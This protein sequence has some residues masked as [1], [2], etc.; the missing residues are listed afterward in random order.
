VD[1]SAGFLHSLELLE[2]LGTSATLVAHGTDVA[3]P[4]I[5]VPDLQSS[6]ADRRL[7]DLPSVWHAIRHVRDRRRLPEMPGALRSDNVFGLWSFPILERVD[8]VFPNYDLLS[9]SP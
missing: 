2:E 4:G 7:L 3:P 5:R 8:S 6:A 1:G 9:N